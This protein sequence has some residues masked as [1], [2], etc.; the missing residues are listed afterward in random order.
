MWLFEQIR[1]YEM[2][3]SKREAWFE[4]KLEKSLY[5][6]ALSYKAEIHFS[7]AVSLWSFICVY[8]L[9]QWNRMQTEKSN[10]LFHKWNF[11]LF[12]KFHWM[13]VI[14][15]E[16]KFTFWIVNCFKKVSRKQ[17]ISAVVW[18]SS[19]LNCYF[20]QI[21]W[22]YWNALFKKFCIYTKLKFFTVFIFWPLLFVLWSLLKN[23]LLYNLLYEEPL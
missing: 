16:L 7:T 12:V 17:N 9:K 21:V 11:C 19:P 10:T 3:F 6:Q 5:L 14:F 1:N 18:F 13:T 22:F 4:S 15:L 23:N 20:L 2:V 8:N